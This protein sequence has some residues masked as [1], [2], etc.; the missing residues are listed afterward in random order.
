M[1]SYAKKMG[2]YTGE[3]FHQIKNCEYKQGEK[4]TN[5]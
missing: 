2:V 3:R 5:G 4:K 1:W